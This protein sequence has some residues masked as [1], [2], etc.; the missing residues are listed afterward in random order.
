[1][2]RNNQFIIIIFTL[3]FEMDL[4]LRLYFVLVLIVLMPAIQHVES[5]KVKWTQILLIY[6]FNIEYNNK[7]RGFVVVVVKNAYYLFKGCSMKC[8]NNGTCVTILDLFSWCLC[9]ESYRGAYCEQ[10]TCF[11]EN[12]TCS[13]FGNSICL[14][15][16]KNVSSSNVL[17]K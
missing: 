9:T 3:F 5:S 2:H 17:G 7:L 8:Y 15:N 10:C 16:N 6:C 1:M 11:M 14:T 4:N 12:K 13:F